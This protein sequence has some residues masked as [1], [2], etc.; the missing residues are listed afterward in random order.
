MRPRPVVFECDSGE[1]A[2]RVL[3]LHDAA[4]RDRRGTRRLSEAPARSLREAPT[5]SLR[6]AAA[7]HVRF[8]AGGRRGR[9][10]SR[11]RPATAAA[12]SALAAGAI[13]TAISRRLNLCCLVS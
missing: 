12:S 5:P 3:G 4:L 11:S 6:E 8:F 7:R 2:P 1:D 9:F 13:L 10:V